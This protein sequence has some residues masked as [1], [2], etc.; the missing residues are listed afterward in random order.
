MALPIVASL[1]RLVASPAARRGVVGMLDDVLG[2]N[3]SRQLAGLADAI[4]NLRFDIQIKGAP[5]LQRALL[6]VPGNI[7]RELQKAMLRAA[8]KVADDLRAEANTSLD[9]PKPY[10]INAIRAR[11]GSK[12]LEA[13]AEVRQDSPALKYLHPLVH[14]TARRPTKPFEARLAAAFGRP[15]VPGPGARLDQHGNIDRRQL[16]AIFQHLGGSGSAAAVRRAGGRYFVMPEGANAAPGVYFRE[17]F[18]RNITPVL[19]FVGSARY[20]P[21]TFDFYGIGLRSAQRHVRPML[22]AAVR[23]GIAKSSVRGQASP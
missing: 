7:E 21:K 19:L 22:E 1:A 20:R 8:W 3:Q 23:A 16:A 10:T 14:G 13:V 6:R 9:R 12:P 11:R 2:G 4:G 18:G 5:A 17:A 15:V